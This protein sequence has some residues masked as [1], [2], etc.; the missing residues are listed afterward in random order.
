MKIV[1][2]FPSTSQD[3]YQLNVT[4]LIKNASRN[5]G[6]ESLVTMKADGSI[7]S[8]TYSE[9][10]ERIK[11]LAN[12]LNKLGIGAADR[13]GVLDWNTHRHYELYFG[14]PGIGAVLLQMNMRLTSQELIYI[15]NHSGVKLIFVDESLIHIAEAISSELQ[16]VIGY[17]IMSDG[18]VTDLKT[19][20]QPIF[21]YEELLGE[22]SAKYEW[23]MIDER[24][25]YA[26]CYTSGT[27]G[28]PKGVYYSHR[29]IYLHALQVGLSYE[30]TDKDCL[31]LLTPMF[32][33]M[34]WGF[35]QISTLVGARLLLAGRYS[36]ED[37]GPIIEL[38]EN[39]KVTFVGGATIIFMSMLEYIRN[40]K[41]KP[42]F[43]GVRFLSG[44][45]EP[46][47]SMIKGIYEMTGA[48]VHQA[49]GATETTPF[50][51]V[52]RLRPGLRKKL[53]EEEMWKYKSKHG[54]ILPGIDLKIIDVQGQEL[55]HDGESVGEILVRGPWI[56]GSY[57]NSP[58]TESQ[59]TD[60]G[61]WK[62]GDVGSIN[63]EGYLRMVD[64]VKDLIK[65]G[66]EWISSV[67][68]ENEIMRHPGVREA[69]VIGVP[70]P[71][72]EE[73]PVAFVALKEAF[74]Q[75]VTKDDI[76]D[77]LGKAFS[78]WQLPDHVEF[79]DEIP[80]TSVGKFNKKILKEK[81][82]YILSE[83]NNHRDP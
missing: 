25:T 72:W 27:T 32:H 52:N 80:K 2:G 6:C 28:K 10:Y 35:P 46:P 58:G 54:Y 24:S 37:F 83:A 20:L 53:T 42:D 40:M 7:F 78:K 34:G 11:R 67:D 74:K 5:F 76:V 33:A 15:G 57:F 66:G 50:V 12:A 63:P 44:A 62:S 48:D 61:Y 59:F 4:S 56:A 68:M 23:P 60:D 45:S 75:N 51:T 81:Y 64:R 69:T 29:N 31:L 17:V 9:A 41:K 16:S 13:I 70:H 30:F 79:I 39:E 21:S 18:K 3:D 19:K 49:W 38:M 55:P 77:H 73:R 14:I 36:L 8:Y 71:K 22:A 1:K 82:R 65:S 43:S 47:L 26:A